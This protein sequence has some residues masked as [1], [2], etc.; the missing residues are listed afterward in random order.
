MSESLVNDVFHR[1]M[2]L[3]TFY[4]TLNGSEESYFGQ[5]GLIRGERLP[6]SPEN[7]D[8]TEA[9]RRR[10]AAYMQ[11]SCFEATPLTAL[12]NVINE[13]DETYTMAK[14]YCASPPLT[15]SAITFPD[16]G[17]VLTE[18][19]LIEIRSATETDE[20]IMWESQGVTNG[21]TIV[22]SAHF[23][24]KKP[25]SYEKVPDG[26]QPRAGQK[27][28]IAVYR[29]FEITAEDAGAA[30]GTDLKK[31][32]GEKNLV[33]VYTGEITAVSR[34]CSVFEHSINT[35]CGCSGAIVFLLDKNQRDEDM[36][37][38]GKAM[39]V[40]VGGSPEGHLANIAFKI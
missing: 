37:H 16:G 19:D 6:S 3:E 31:I 38:A 23:L 14:L 5:V 9:K 10:T 40:H 22:N 30:E 1:A 36:E 39:G 8:R 13:E 2:C 15:A 11:S 4:S 17:R 32:F 21:N 24:T 18:N 12:H 29:R 26:F 34:E 28:G 20:A 7:V 35:F 25:L 33:C 27:I